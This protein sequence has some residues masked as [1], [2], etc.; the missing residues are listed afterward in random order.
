MVTDCAADRRSTEQ[1]STGTAQTA[2]CHL[3]P[4]ALDP[5]VRSTL[6]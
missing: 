1:H 4:L 3:Y 5:I 6:K 2:P